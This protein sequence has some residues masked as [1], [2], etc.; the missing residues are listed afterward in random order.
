MHFCLRLILRYF[1][2][3]WCDFIITIVSF[4][5]RIFIFFLLLLFFNVV[6]CNINHSDG[7]LTHTCRHTNLKWRFAALFKC[8]HANDCYKNR[9]SF[10]F[11]HPGKISFNNNFLLPC[12][13]FYADHYFILLK[14]NLCILEKTVYILF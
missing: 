6:D 4:T 2:P 13:R 11:V 7:I 3:P 12:G 1:N 9:E 8:F 5:R 10:D 14:A